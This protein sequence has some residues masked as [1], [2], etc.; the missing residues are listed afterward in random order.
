MGSRPRRRQLSGQRGNEHG[1]RKDSQAGGDD[2]ESVHQAGRAEDNTTGRRYSTS[3]IE[4]SFWMTTFAPSA[5]F[6]GEL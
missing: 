5:V 1:S 2:R 3:L 4:P 6:A